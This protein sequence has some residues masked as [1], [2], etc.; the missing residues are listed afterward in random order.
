MG[1]GNAVDLGG[2][3]CPRVVGQGGGKG[4]FTSCGVGFEFGEIWG[5]LEW[6]W[7]LGCHRGLC[8]WLAMAIPQ[9]PLVERGRSE[10]PFPRRVR[11]GG[12]MS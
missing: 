10:I 8:G 6:V 7:A 4:C 9:N 11:E 1:T 3:E 12:E 5:N 2:E